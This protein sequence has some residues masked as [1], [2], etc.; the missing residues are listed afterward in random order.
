M[1]EAENVLN[2]KKFK[3]IL[4]QGILMKLDRKQKM[5]KKL[6]IKKNYIDENKIET[7]E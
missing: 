5:K 1:N 4:I 2:Y 3:S 7:C 6:N